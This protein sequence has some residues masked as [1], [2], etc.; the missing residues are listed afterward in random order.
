MFDWANHLS[1][2]LI[3]DNKIIR[4]NEST[5]DRTD[6]ITSFTILKKNRSY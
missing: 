1:E 2:S 6:E 5:S 4:M 3:R